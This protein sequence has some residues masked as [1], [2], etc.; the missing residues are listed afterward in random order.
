M[1]NADARLLRQQIDAINKPLIAVIITHGH[2]D[3][4]NGTDIVINGFNKV[5]V[6]STEGVRDCINDTVDAK[7]LKWKPHFGENWPEHKI[8]PNQLVK[9]GEVISLDGLRYRFRDLGAAESTSDLFFTLGENN[10]IVFVGDVVFNNMHG[11]MNDGNSAQWL[12][13]LQALLSEL[14][15]TKQLFTGHGA[16][17]NTAQLIKS[18]ID[19][20]DYYRSTL[21]GMLGESPFLNDLQKHS[22]EQLLMSNFPEYQLTSFIKAGIDAVVQELNIEKSPSKGSYLL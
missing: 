2:P 18:Q 19:Y 22:F 15:D 6:I 8:L 7:E 9:D 17:G 4:Y 5:P 21:E 14:K 12:A 16:S 20:I 11:F 1:I 10:S 13:V 3:H